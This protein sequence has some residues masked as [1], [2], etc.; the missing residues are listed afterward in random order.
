ME[1]IALVSLGT[2]CNPLAP[3]TGTYGV[4]L[5][6]AHPFSLCLFFLH[7]FP[8]YFPVAID[9]FLFCFA[10]LSLGFFLGFHLI[11]VDLCDLSVRRRTQQLSYKQISVASAFGSFFLVTSYAKSS[12]QPAI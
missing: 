12:F 11:S 5:G 9:C 8:V 7:I 4:K 6:Q 2:A 3:G 1:K 10:L